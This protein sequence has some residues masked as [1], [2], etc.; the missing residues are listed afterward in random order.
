VSSPERAAWAIALAAVM[1][2]AAVGCTRPPDGPVEPHWDHTRC[3]RCGM[4]VSEPRFAAQ[5]Q[6]ADGTVLHYDDPGC[7]LAHE[8]PERGALAEAHAVWFHHA[9]TPR[10]VPLA[11][12]GFV[13]AENTPMDFGLAAVERAARPEALDLEAARA[14]V[15]ARAEATP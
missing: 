11:D 5:V 1:V 4:L 9:E 3:A 14:H 7:L 6:R 12:V 10:W 2:A 13:P 8:G 15:R